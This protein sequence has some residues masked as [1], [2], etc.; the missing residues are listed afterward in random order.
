M[1][2]FPIRTNVLVDDIRGIVVLESSPGR[3]V[4]YNANSQ[5]CEMAIRVELWEK[6]MSAT[7]ERN[8]LTQA[9]EDSARYFAGNRFMR[10]ERQRS[11]CFNQ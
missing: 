2:H 7:V 8:N 5:E 11:G 3:H 4:F 6:A 10:Q 1:S 9:E